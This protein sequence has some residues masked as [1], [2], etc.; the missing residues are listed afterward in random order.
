M[1]TDKDEQPFKN[2]LN[3]A[4]DDSLNKLSPETRQSLRNSREQA[5]AR[6]VKPAFWSRQTYRL[7]LA[8]AMAFS[9]AIVVALPLWQNEGT[10]ELSSGISQTSELDDLFMLAEI[11][12]DTLQLVEDIEFALWLTEEMEQ[13]TER[14]PFEEQTQTQADPLQLE[15]AAKVSE[16]FIYGITDHV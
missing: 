10:V 16:L 8:T 1:H 11:D 3:S 2:T 4:L 7:P 13:Q 5:L 15:Q 14:N 12:D 9:L 6:A